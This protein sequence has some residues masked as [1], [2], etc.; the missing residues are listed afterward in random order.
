MNIKRLIARI[1]I[2]GKDIVKG[3]NLEGLRVLGNPEKFSLKYYTDGIDEIYIQD[4]V[5]SMYGR[6]NLHNVIKKISQNIFVPITIGGGIRSLHDIK[7][8]LRAGADKVAINTAAIKNPQFI[9]EAVKEFGS[10]TIVISIEA[11]KASNGDYYI[12]HDNGR[13]ETDIN[14]ISWVKKV[15][16]LGSG[17][18]F[19]TSIENEGTGKGYNL[20]LLEK[21]KK[22]I[23]IPFVYHGGINS[24]ENILNLLKNFN[25]IDG[26]SMSSI[27]H[28]SN[29]QD[30]NIAN[31]ENIEGNEEFLK[32][33]FLL[34]KF[35][36]ISIIDLK[37]FLKKNNI[38][39]RL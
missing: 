36:K 39:V 6:N 32:K 3:V 24:K 25:F 7:E 37:K 12:Y 16:D 23:K 1:D 20:D 9:N 33:K 15:Q 28:Y 5:A 11:L 22:I 19:L 18:I 14:L 31:Y 21:I 10:S 30:K 29:L 8:I 4:V 26:V 17:E 38:E 35:E 13:E 34:K 2:K 27:L